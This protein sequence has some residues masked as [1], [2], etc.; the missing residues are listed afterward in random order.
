MNDYCSERGWRG[1]EL[2]LPPAAPNMSDSHALCVEFSFPS[3]L[4]IFTT[5]AISFE[6]C[7]KSFHKSIKSGLPRTVSD[8]VWGFTQAKWLPGYPPDQIS[9]YFERR[10]KKT[11]S[12]E[13]AKSEPLSFIIA[14]VFRGHQRREMTAEAKR[15]YL[16]RNENFLSEM[17]TFLRIESILAKFNNKKQ[18]SG[19]IS[20][21]TSHSGTYINKHI[22]DIV[23]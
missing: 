15:R 22:I 21:T 9:F 7:T 16:W 2:L 4:L 10:W 6:Q 12:G 8:A 17:E 18:P 20:G 14:V 3:A 11:D 19:L 13:E 1:S 5:P 23:V